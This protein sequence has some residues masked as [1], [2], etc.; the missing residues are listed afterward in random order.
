MH[1]STVRKP[2]AHLSPHSSACP[3]WREAQGE[4]QAAK[5]PHNQQAHL[6]SYLATFLSNLTL[7]LEAPTPSPGGTFQAFPGTEQ[8]TALRVWYTAGAQ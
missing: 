2:G 4:A 7:A 8:A 1:C 3:S 6:R 5:I